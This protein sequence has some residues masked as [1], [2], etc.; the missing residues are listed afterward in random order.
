MLGER[1]VASG[2]MV[3]LLSDE[4][5]GVFMRRKIAKALSTL[6]E[7]SVAVDLTQLLTDE[8]LH[9]FVRTSI[10]E[11]LGN[12][13][14]PTVSVELVELLADKKLEVDLR[15]SITSTLGA[16]ANDLA[17]VAGLLNSLPDK[18]ICESVYRA[19]WNVS[20]RAR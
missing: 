17:T 3:Q 10:A 15:R 18:D 9:E 20:R 5:L 8:R 1:S 2:V 4:R 11:A 14:E 7:R 12:L 13:G 6:G 19:L 16:Y